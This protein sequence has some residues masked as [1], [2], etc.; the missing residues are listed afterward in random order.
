MI[1]SRYVLSAAHCII[2]NYNL[3]QVRLGEWD[4]STA[5]D[6]DSGDC[7]DPVQDINVESI[8]SPKTYD[9]SKN[10]EHDIALLRLARPARMSYFVKP[11]CLPLV[12]SLMGNS[13]DASQKFVVAGWGKTEKL[14]KS[15][16]KLKL[17]L[18]GVEHD[19]CK[20][21]YASHKDKVIISSS[22]VCAGGEKGKDSCQGDSGGPLMGLYNDGRGGNYYYLAGIVSFGIGCGNAGWPG[23]YTRVSSY[24]NWI[25]SN[26]RE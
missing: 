18:G 7:A 2:E 26:I 4:T 3:R 8:F 12:E 14:Q 6:C 23:V 15:D 13:R 5:L 17:Q 21:K 9:F 20:K 22:Q 24:I 19:A 10:N 1:S 16:R 25:Q 11:I